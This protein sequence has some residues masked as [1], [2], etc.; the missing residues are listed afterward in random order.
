MLRIDEISATIAPENQQK[1]A[2]LFIGGLASREEQDNI[3]D[4]LSKKDMVRL[5][6]DGEVEIKCD[7]K[8]MKMVLRSAGLLEGEDE[9]DVPRRRRKL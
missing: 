8:D 4:E 2:G 9:A 3:V 5:Y 7:W 6:G 1:L